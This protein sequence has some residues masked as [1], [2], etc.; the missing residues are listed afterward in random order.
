LLIQQWRMDYLDS[1]RTF[2][3]VAKAGSFAE[4]ARKL[5]LSPS[6]VTRSIA[7][8]EEHL[9]HVLLSRTT[10][11]VRV[12]ERGRI[13][14]DRC[15]QI[16]DDVND[17]ER[18]VRGEDAEL[19]GE[20]TVAAP[21]MFGRLHVLPVVGVLLAAHRALAVRLV[22]SDRNAHLVDDG[23][24]VAVRIGELADSAAIAVKLATVQ[25]TVVASPS[26]VATRGAPKTPKDLV[27]HDVIAFESIELTNEWRFRD[28]KAVRVTP[29]LTLNSADAAI[30][31]AEAGLGITRALSYQVQASVRV[32]RLVVLLPAY[33][34]HELP[35]SAIYSTRRGAASSVAAFVSAARER[36]RASPLEIELAQ[37]PSKSRAKRRN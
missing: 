33:A 3:A 30:S 12:T 23:V 27:G 7:Q 26:Y 6:V 19:R 32:G 21:V 35:V 25:R 1:M 8:L 5:R 17:A 15:D 13:Y 9:G 2:A 34:P 28:D 36:F 29:R 14:L 16:L 31:A 10:R 20:L 4:A 18:L 11:S 24:D 37:S 22:L